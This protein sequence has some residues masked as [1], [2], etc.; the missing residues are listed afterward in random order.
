[1]PGISQGKYQLSRLSQ[2]SFEASYNHGA[3]FKFVLPYSKY[4]PSRPS[5]ILYD[6]P[7]SRSITRQLRNPIVRI[8]FGNT[9]VFRAAMPEAAVNENHELLFPKHKIW[10]TEQPLIPTPSGDLIASH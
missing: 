4:S 3:I 1:V 10:R 9:T 2:C 6:A 5:E 8:F 7:I